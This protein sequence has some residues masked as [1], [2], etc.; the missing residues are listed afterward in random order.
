MR[1]KAF[2]YYNLVVFSPSSFI[3]SLYQSPVGFFLDWTLD[4]AGWGGLFVLPCCGFSCRLTS[5]CR[6]FWRRTKASRWPCHMSFRVGYIIGRLYYIERLYYVLLYHNCHHK[7]LQ[8]SSFVFFSRMF[9]LYIH[10]I[11]MFFCLRCLRQVFCNCDPLLDPFQEPLGGEIEV[12][13][14]APTFREG[15]TGK[16]LVLNMLEFW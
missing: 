12:E 15:I 16:T 5:K 4:P 10:S 11:W 1:F 6:G 13:S 3:S 7:S 8:C 14:G 2:L 9:I